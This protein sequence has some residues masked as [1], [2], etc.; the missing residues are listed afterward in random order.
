MYR[1]REREGGGEGQSGLLL[2]APDWSSVPELA[3]SEFDTTY[4]LEVESQ[5]SFR[6]QT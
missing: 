2:L 1:E 6:Q 4:E 5:K 3:I